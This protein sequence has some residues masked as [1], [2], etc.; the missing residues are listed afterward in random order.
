MYLMISAYFKF[1]V[2]PLRRLSSYEKSERVTE[3]ASV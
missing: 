2:L 3:L 1:A